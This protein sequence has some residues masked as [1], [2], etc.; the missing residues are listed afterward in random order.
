MSTP[1]ASA[2]KHT[3]D[4]GDVDALRK[5]VDQGGTLVINNALG[6]ATFHKAA[7]REMRRVFPADEFR[8]LPQTH[9]IFRSLNTIES[10]KFTPALMKDKGGKLQG[11]PVLFGVEIK[12]KLRVI[13]SPHDLEGGWNEVRYPL[14]RGY[15]SDSA[16]K[17]GCNIIMFAMTN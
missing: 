2:L 5:H 9:E 4:V 6:L 12:G 10:V 7:V 1:D 16:K 11:R 8:L 15:Q 14:S 13:Y 17:L 3:I